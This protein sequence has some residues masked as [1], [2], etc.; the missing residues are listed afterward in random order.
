[1]QSKLWLIACVVLAS[2]PTSAL[3]ARGHLNPL[4]MHQKHV[5]TVKFEHLAQP[6]HPMARLH[7]KRHACK[8]P[9]SNGAKR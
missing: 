4:I 7:H 8:I 5:P 3:A 2:V 9:T 6:C 1:M